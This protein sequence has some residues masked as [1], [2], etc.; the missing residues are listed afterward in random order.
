MNPQSIPAEP[1]RQAEQIPPQE[2][3]A[4]PVEDKS[5]SAAAV[6]LEQTQARQTDERA[7]L[8]VP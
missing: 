8:F 4:A 3:S 6:L 7:V 2:K 5:L 1:P